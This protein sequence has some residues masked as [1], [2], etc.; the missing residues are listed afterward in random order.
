MLRIAGIDVLRVVDRDRVAAFRRG[1]QAQEAVTRL[2]SPPRQRV[3]VERDFHA[4][5]PRLDAVVRDDVLDEVR[6]RRERKLLRAQHRRAQVC[7][8]IVE[9]GDIGGQVGGELLSV[10]EFV[11]EH[12]FDFQLVV[13]RDVISR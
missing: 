9:N 7:V 2:D 1:G 12:R 4:T 10:T 13:V 5:G 11:G 8:L 3:P 6:C